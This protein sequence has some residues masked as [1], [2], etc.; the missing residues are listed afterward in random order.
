MRI[1]FFGSGSF[2]QK[3][4]DQ[5][6]GN[7]QFSL[8]EFVAFADNNQDLH[9][10]Y[11]CGKKIISS[12]EIHSYSPDLILIASS[13]YESEIRKQLIEE[14]KI[15]ERMIYTYEEYLRL[16]YAASV[17]RK[18]YEHL[19]QSIIRSYNKKPI[20]IYTAI[21]GDYDSLKEPQFIAD[22]LTYVCLTNNPNI[23]SK[24]W[25]VEYVK[26]NRMDNV[27]LA[28]HIKL[29]PHLYFKDDE[30][31]IWVDGKYQIMDDLRMYVTQYQKKS[32]IL[33]FPHPQRDCI[34]DEVAACI[35]LQKGNNKD[36]IIQVA[37]YLR[38]GYPL[39]NGLYETGCIVREHNNDLVKYLMSEWENEIEKYSFRDQLSFPYICWKNNFMPDICDLDINHNQ[40]LL[41]KRDLYV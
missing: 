11:F 22:D 35:A 21:T 1:I 37:D 18:N 40:W 34:C 4:W 39:H 19:G 33:C 27:H 5:M 6:Q 32:A 20:L 13:L 16:S 29:N 28:R 24:N 9:G 3:I 2:A 36:M 23:R 7:P 14:I 30:M 26:D 41:Q 31:S 38:D 17:Y 12:S 8:D 25:I 15:P 10:K